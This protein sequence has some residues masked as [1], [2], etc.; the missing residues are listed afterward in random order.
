[1]VKLRW[2]Q[3]ARNHSIVGRF[4]PHQSVRDV[5]FGA[6]SR[7]I[8]GAIVSAV[9]SPPRTGRAVDIETARTERSVA[10]EEAFRKVSGSS[11][12]M[13][14]IIIIAIASGDVGVVIVS[15]EMSTAFVV[16]AVDDGTRLGGGGIG[17]G[18]SSGIVII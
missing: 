11:R 7:Q 2:A 3:L 8:G 5:D 16:S 12:L 1:M 18:G 4:V 9:L 14:V 13:G 17:D 15:I 6:I 10:I